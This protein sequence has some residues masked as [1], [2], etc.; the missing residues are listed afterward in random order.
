MNL[1]MTSHVYLKVVYIV[2]LFVDDKGGEI[3]ELMI[4]MIAIFAL[5]HVCYDCHICIMLR[6]QELTS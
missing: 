6:Y 3:Y 5:C 2:L 1:L 4:T